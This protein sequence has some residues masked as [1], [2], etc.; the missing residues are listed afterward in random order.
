MIDLILYVFGILYIAC[1]FFCIFIYIS[2][3]VVSIIAL[4]YR[5]EVDRL[6]KEIK[7]SEG[8]ISLIKFK[9]MKRDVWMNRAF[10]MYR[11]M[12]IALTLLIL[13]SILWAPHLD[14]FNALIST[15]H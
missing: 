1:I 14:A 13:Y 2:G 12:V 6:Y 15:V 8:K 11:N 7:H 10:K 3:F 9:I 5:F 4:C